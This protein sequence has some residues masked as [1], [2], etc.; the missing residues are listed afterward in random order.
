LH[1]CL[2][3]FA[4]E[5]GYSI[6]TVKREIF[7]GIVNKDVFLKDSVKIKGKWVEEYKSIKDPNI[8]LTEAIERF[9]H[10]CAKE[11]D[12]YIPNPNERGF[13]SWVMQVMQQENK[14]IFFYL[15][16]II[17]LEPKCIA[18]RFFIFFKL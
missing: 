12:L 5:F 8:N 9:R 1:L 4:T 11:A 17:I 14:D 16:L 3:I 15:G 2:S 13:N 7:K 10:Y 6:E 18:F